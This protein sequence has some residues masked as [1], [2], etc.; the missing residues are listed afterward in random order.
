M[1]IEK[2]DHISNFISQVKNCLKN[3][4]TPITNS[5]ICKYALLIIKI[6]GQFK[7]I[8]KLSNTKQI[9]GKMHRN[10]FM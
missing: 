3:Q 5:R 9:L 6:D 1:W 2:N 10:N 7:N 4:E 8:Y